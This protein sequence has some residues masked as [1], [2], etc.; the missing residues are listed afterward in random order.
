MGR[1]KV[2]IALNGHG[3][4]F[5]VNIKRTSQ[6]V[7]TNIFLN[8]D[9]NL[10]VTNVAVSKRRNVQGTSKF[11][12]WWVGDTVP[13]P[14]FEGGWTF[15]GKLKVATNRTRDWYRVFCYMLD[16]FIAQSY[17]LNIR[18]LTQQ[19]QITTTT[20]IAKI[21]ILQKWCTLDKPHLKNPFFDY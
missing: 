12:S 14:S 4:L 11:W 2:I 6:I 20:H 15:L 17:K 7:H 13:D 8:I 1:E 9:H 18:R 5:T 3:H 16:N 21:Y 19:K 10:I